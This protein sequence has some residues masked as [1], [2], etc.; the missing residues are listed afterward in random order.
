MSTNLDSSNISD[1]IKTATENV[2]N[3]TEE[4]ISTASGADLTDNT[5]TVTVNGVETELNKDDYD[6][7]KF[8]NDLVHG[9]MKQD[10]KKALDDFKTNLKEEIKNKNQ[11]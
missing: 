2:I 6:K 3:K 1:I 8:E 4:T 7:M 10:I 9:Q 5:I 11:I